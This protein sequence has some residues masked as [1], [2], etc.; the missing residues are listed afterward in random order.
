MANNPHDIIA[1]AIPYY[2][3]KG[4]RH[5]YASDILAKL[6]KAGFEIRKKSM[7]SCGPN[8]PDD[9]C[10]EPGSF[11]HPIENPNMIANDVGWT[12][13]Q[14]KHPSIAQD[15]CGGFS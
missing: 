15:L 4:R 8:E 12:G 6:D 5:A 14:P 1:N 7:C 10:V 2:P 11:P 3:R 9:D 13:L